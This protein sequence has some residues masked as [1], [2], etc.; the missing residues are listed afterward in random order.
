MNAQIAREVAGAPRE[1]FKLSD[2]QRAEFLKYASTPAAIKARDLMNDASVKEEY[3]AAL[4]GAF[5]K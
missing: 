5:H 3:T 1:P 2:E 4:R